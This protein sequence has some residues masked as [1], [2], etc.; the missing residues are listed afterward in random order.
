MER[1]SELAEAVAR[2]KAQMNT[3]KKEFAVE[4]ASCRGHTAR[5]PSVT[6]TTQRPSK[7]L[8][9][10]AGPSLSGPDQGNFRAALDRIEAWTLPPALFGLFAR[11]GAAIV[12]VCFVEAV[13]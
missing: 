2:L 3:R 13:G 10:R 11:A 8:A 1:Q 4:Q 9:Q 7:G 5:V 12:W 6:G